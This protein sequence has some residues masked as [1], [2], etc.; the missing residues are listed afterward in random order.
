MAANNYDRFPLQR[1]LMMMWGVGRSSFCA[2][3]WNSRAIFAKKFTFLPQIALFWVFLLGPI[4]TFVISIDFCLKWKIMQLYI[5][6]ITS[7]LVVIN[8]FEIQFWGKNMH[9]WP[10]LVNF[11]ISKQKCS[12]TLKFWLKIS[13]NQQNHTNYADCIFHRA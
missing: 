10:F 12:K 4:Q 11:E 13:Q 2:L 5:Y 1:S 3:G 7:N 6:K 8:S 9:F